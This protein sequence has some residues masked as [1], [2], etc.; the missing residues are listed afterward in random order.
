MAPAP[1]N[2]VAHPDIVVLKD[3]DNG[4]R[5]RIMFT[6]RS[7]NKAPTIVLRVEGAYTL[8]SRLDGKL[9]TDKAASAFKM[10]LHGTGAT[11]H[12][13]ELD[14]ASGSV[15]RIFVE[16]RIPGL[17]GGAGGARPAHI[18]LSEMTVS[19]DMLVFR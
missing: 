11:D 6:L 18:P 14:L 8:A 10:S 1:R 19:S 3:D 12:K 2:K 5:R 9:L 13:V 7:Q 15:A 16:E 17:P 4:A